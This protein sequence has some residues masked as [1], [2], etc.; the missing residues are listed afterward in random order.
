MTTA[1][2][3]ADTEQLLCD[4]LGPLADAPVGT[5]IPQTGSKFVRVIRTGGPRTTKVSESAQE[6]FD[7]YDVTESGAAQF[8]QQIRQL[9]NQL[10][11]TKL[12]P[13]QVYGVTEFSGPANDPDP[14]HASF[15]YSFTAAIHLRAAS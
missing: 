5:R 11:G 3:F 4:H 7:C 8:A 14:E 12:G 10:P 13:C 15:R 2:Q 1:P 6:T 9:V